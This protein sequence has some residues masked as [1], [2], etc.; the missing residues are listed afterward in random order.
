MLAEIRQKNLF[1]FIVLPTFFDLDRYVALWRSRAL[2]HIYTGK[3]FER[4]YFMFFNTERKK[5]LYIYGKKTYSYKMPKANFFGRFP[6]GYMVNEAEYRKKKL[7]SL[8]VKKIGARRQVKLSEDEHR[9][10]LWA[11]FKEANIRA[12]NEEKARL[13]G[14]SISTYYNWLDNDPNDVIPKE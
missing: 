10:W 1:I 2:I 6:K 8:G 12:T 7:D 4:G 13:C 14:I 11:R 3:S 5:D 9:R